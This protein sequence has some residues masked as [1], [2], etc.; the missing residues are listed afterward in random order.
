SPT[1]AGQRPSS[2]LA[3]RFHCTESSRRKRQVDSVQ[4][5]D[6]GRSGFAHAGAT[7][8]FMATHTLDWQD[9]FPTMCRKGVVS[10]GNFDGVHRG[11]VA[12]LAEM[13]RQARELTGPVV[14]LLF[15]PH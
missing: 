8:R 14:A 13:Q 11:H 15:D 7:I 3:N 6:D 12:L 5:R 4:W 10:V 9:T 1:C 2:R